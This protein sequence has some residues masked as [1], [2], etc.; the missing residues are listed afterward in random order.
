[1]PNK[2]NDQRSNKKSIA[3]STEWSTT[4]SVRRDRLISER[5]KKGL[6]QGQLAS[7]LGVSIATIS[8]LE[9]GRRK[10]NLEVSL[11]VQELFNLPFE[12]I[13]PDC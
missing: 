4:K 6:T 1:M 13:F 10:P 8:H 7:L 3:P 12:I 5:K 9:N 2:I 11:G